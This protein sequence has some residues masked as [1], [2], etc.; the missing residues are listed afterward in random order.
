MTRQTTIRVDDRHAAVVKAIQSESAQTDRVPY[1]DS[2]AEIYRYVLDA[3]IEAMLDDEPEEGVDD[4]NLAEL[5]PR[6]VLAEHGRKKIKNKGRQKFLSADIAG[7]FERKTTEL[8]E[9]EDYRVSPEKVEEIQEDYLAEIDLYRDLD[10]LSNQEAEEQAEAIRSRVETYAEEYDAAQSAPST[11]EVPDEVRLGRA[12]ERLR[13]DAEGFLGDLRERVDQPMSTADD[14]RRA[15]AS[16]YAVDVSAIDAVLD[17]VT[18][19]GVDGRQALKS[20]NS[21]ELPSPEDLITNDL[22]PGDAPE[23]EGETE[24]VEQVDDEVDR[25]VDDTRSETLQIR[26]TEVEQEGDD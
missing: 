7:R 24:R 18:P 4:A 8:F 2:R 14:I 5:V 1:L 16:E 3:G 15:M 13:A 12:I 25:V 9:G 19:E 22:G 26:P 17:A 10:Y 21:D 6:H 20:T 11:R 23:V